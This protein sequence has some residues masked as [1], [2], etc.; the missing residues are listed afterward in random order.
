MRNHINVM[1]VSYV[2]LSPLKFVEISFFI[3]YFYSVY[4]LRVIIYCVMNA[5][6]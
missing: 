1:I 6:T 4:Y 2:I 5:T 3:A